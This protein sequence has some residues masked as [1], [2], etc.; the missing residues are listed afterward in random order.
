[1]NLYKQRF[2]EEGNQF[3]RS[4]FAI[5]PLAVARTGTQQSR[6]RTSRAPSYRAKKALLICLDGVRPDA[7]LFASTPNIDRLLTKGRAAYSFHA[8]CEARS[9]SGPSWA[10]VFTG[11]LM[12][13]HGVRDNAIG[14]AA[15]C[16]PRRQESEALLPGPNL[17]ELAK[18]Q[19]PGTT[20][21]LLVA[22][23][24]V[25]ALGG[26]SWGGIEA[27]LGAG[28]DD[29]AGFHGTSEM[30]NVRLATAECTRSC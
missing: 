19:R 11:L 20:T 12:D 5:G 25:A 16:A 21:Q 29:M 17:F 27:I 26:S 18:C 22:D 3:C 7:L 2:E 9:L 13:Q 8:Q 15:R 1:M 28:C 24:P 14:A 10:S 23:S 6:Q 4:M 30:E